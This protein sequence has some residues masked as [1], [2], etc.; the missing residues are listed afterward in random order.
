MSSL[1]SYS[2]LATKVRAMESNLLTTKEYEDIANL[3]SIPEIVAYLSNHPG[4]SDLFNSVDINMIHRGELERI[5]ALS[6]YKNFSKLYNFMGMKQRKYMQLYFIK[7]ELY[8]LKLAFRQIFE[9]KPVTI[10][11]SILGPYFAKY[12]AIP[13]QELTGITTIE[14]CLEAI[15]NTRFYAP[16]KRVYELGNASLF[17]YESCLDVLQFTIVWKDKSKY[18]SGIDL[19]VITEDYGYRIDIINLQWIYRLKSYYKTSGAD[20]YAFLIPINFK[21]K[22]HQIKELIDTE[23]ISELTALI[24]NTYY[25]K[26]IREISS[27]SE[28]ALE[29]VYRIVMDSFHQKAVRNNPYS[30]ACVE[31]FL[32]LKQKEISTLITITEC[33]RY[34]YTA[35]EILNIIH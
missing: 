6:R 28:I 31:D 8:V 10:D 5:L 20:I 17:D 13:L 30:L 1:L 26:I 25:G 35:E 15:K 9:N 27:T 12:S 14:Q 33:I 16:L 7:Y 3:H 34:S 11:S 4:Y 24:F 23:N 21:L 32:Y 18:L 22:K 29:K 19:K 2:G